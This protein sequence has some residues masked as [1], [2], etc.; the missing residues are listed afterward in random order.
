MQPAGHEPNGVF[1]VLA[2]EHGAPTVVNIADKMSGPRP[3]VL[4]RGQQPI[5][6]AAALQRAAERLQREHE[7]WSVR[8]R[9]DGPQITLALDFDDFAYTSVY[10]V[11]DGAITPRRHRHV[12]MRDGAVALTASIVV[13]LIVLGAGLAYNYR[14]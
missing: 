14:A 6:D 8:P 7:Q 4:D 13:S 1:Y 10:D 3:I 9:V 11:R 12:E 2:D 5:A